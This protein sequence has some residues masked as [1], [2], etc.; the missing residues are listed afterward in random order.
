MWSEHLF[1]AG[2]DIAAAGIVM[3][4]RWS[5]LNEDIKISAD[6]VKKIKKGGITLIIAGILLALLGIIA[7]TKAFSLWSSE[8]D[9]FITVGAAGISHWFC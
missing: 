3:I 6:K 9:K 4:V 5:S 8:A 7:S 2:F 1:S